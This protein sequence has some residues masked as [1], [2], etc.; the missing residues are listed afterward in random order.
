MYCIKWG[1]SYVRITK[2]VEK[3][4]FTVYYTQVATLY[5]FYL[6]VS[7]LILS[8]HFPMILLANPSG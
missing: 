1:Y 5:K 3:S 8:G 6:F 7:R 4:C 2:T